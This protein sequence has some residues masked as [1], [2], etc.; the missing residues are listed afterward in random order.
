M[1]TYGT[2]VGITC[3]G[4]DTRVRH[5]SKGYLAR[6]AALL[7][8]QE[9]EIRCHI[10]PTERDIL[11]LLC[12]ICPFRRAPEQGYHAVRLNANPE[13]ENHTPAMPRQ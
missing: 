11:G 10:R 4:R 7:P 13:N 3:D 2:T 6:S 8:S 1:S 5:P 12:R 9:A